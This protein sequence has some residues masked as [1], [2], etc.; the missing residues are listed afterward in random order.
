MRISAW[1]FT[2]TFGVICV[3]AAQAGKCQWDKE[4]LEFSGSAAQQAACLLRPIK[5]AGHVEDSP[6]VLPAAL[7]NSVGQPIHID[8]AKLR[9]YLKAHGIAESEIGGSLDRPLSKTVGKTPKPA[10]YFVIHDTSA[11]YACKRIEFPA[12]TDRPD[13]SWNKPANYQASKQAH[14]Y[15]TRDGKSY[16][17][18]SRTFETPY[19][20][21]QFENKNDIDTL[22]G[23]FL[24]IENVQLRRPY[25]ADGA[26]LLK[27]NKKGK[28]VCVN[29][30]IAQL[31]G[32][33][34]GQSKRLA[35]VYL[36]A[37]VRARAWLIP[38]FHGVLDLDFGTHDDPQNFDLAAW[39][40]HLCQL[41]SELG[42][43]CAIP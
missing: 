26:P 25:V 28:L 40:G 7:E 2:L 13:N 15:L 8:L 30:Q 14:L 12:I 4:A 19:T 33:S 41:R 10:L 43:I 21:T 27:K 11:L 17:P 5:Q 22:R 9:S 36:A 29:D 18:Q 23:R 34:E 6:A 39:S 35:L 42:D 3:P 32:L 37:S 16:Q 1:I 24:H 38:A 20:A 31:P